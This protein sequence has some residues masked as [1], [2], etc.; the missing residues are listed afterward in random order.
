[1]VFSKLAAMCEKHGIIIRSDEIHCDPLLDPD[2][3]HIPIAT[4]TPEAA[5]RTITLMSPSKYL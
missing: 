5:A 2:K 4:L 3:I 1:M